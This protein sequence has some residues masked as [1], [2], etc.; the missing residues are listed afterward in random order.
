MRKLIVILAVAA[1]FTSCQEDKGYFIS[2]NVDQMEN[3]NMVYVSEL[4]DKTKRPVRVDSTAIKDGRFEL[5]LEDPETP[6]LSFLE[7]EGTPGNVI[8][9]AEDEKINFEIYKDSLRASEVSGGKENRL[10]YD[11]LNHLEKINEKVMKGRTEMRTAYREKD[12]TKLLSLQD[13]EKEIIDNDKVFKKKIVNENPDS[14][15]SIM[16]ISDMLRMKSYPVNEIKEMF[17]GLSEEV[18]NTVIGKQIAEN[19]E[20][21]NKVAVGSKAPNF[22]APTPNGDQLSLKDAMGKVTVIDFWA[23]W[24]KPCRVE[25]PNLVKTYNKYKDEGLSIIGVSLDRPGQKDRWIQAIEEDGLPWHQV[26]NLEFWQDP[27][28]QLYGIKAI[29]AAFVLDEDGTIVARD[30][31]GDALDKKIGELLKKS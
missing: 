21:A 16:V 29:P 20:K 13:T 24:C 6:S 19:L 7:F 5:D 12:S 27:V 1:A 3:G 4:D 14:F 22:T 23:A 2:G 28:A 18:K 9:I 8:Y 26:S 15:V 31:R 17:E 10:L 25:N 30:L 11:Y